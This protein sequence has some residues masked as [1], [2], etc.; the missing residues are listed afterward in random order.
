MYKNQIFIILIVIIIVILFFLLKNCWSSNNT[1]EGFFE[2]DAD[3]YAQHGLINQ[4]GYPRNKPP[5]MHHIVY[6]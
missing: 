4:P 3:V 2:E 5:V 1:N 6:P